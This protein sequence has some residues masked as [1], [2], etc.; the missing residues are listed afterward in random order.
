MKRIRWSLLMILPGRVQIETLQLASYG[1]S[2]CRREES[3]VGGR[4]VGRCAFDG[5]SVCLRQQDVNRRGLW[6]IPVRQV[7][8][9]NSREGLERQRLG[10]W[11]RLLFL[12]LAWSKSR[13]LWL[14]RNRRHLVRPALSRDQLH[15]HIWARHFAEKPWPLRSLRTVLFGGYHET[16]AGYPNSDSGLAI[17]AGGGLDVHLRPG[18]SLRAAE[19]DWLYTRLPNSATLIKANNLRVVTGVVFRF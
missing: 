14:L 11:V 15:L 5:L 16:L 12:P 1:L 9:W 6:R 19:V 4:T 2:Q 7:Q 18:L 17:L 10:R 3:R 13:F 8:R